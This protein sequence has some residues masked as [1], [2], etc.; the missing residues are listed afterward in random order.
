MEIYVD[1]EAKL[2]LHGLVQVNFL[3]MF[4]NLISLWYIGLI[5]FNLLN[6]LVALHKTVGTGE[7]QEVK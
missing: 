2:T 1:D 3:I 4:W 6:L 7:E 5:Y